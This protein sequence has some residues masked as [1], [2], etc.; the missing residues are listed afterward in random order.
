M[1]AH[2][3]FDDLPGFRPGIIFGAIVPQAKEGSSGFRVGG[4]PDASES[5]AQG[6]DSGP[7]VLPLPF[8]AQTLPDF[9]GFS[10]EPSP[11]GTVG[12]VAGAS[13]EG[14][15]DVEAERGALVLAGERCIPVK[16]E[17]ASVAEVH[18]AVAVDAHGEGVPPEVE[19]AFVVGMQLRGR[20]VGDVA[21]SVGGGVQVVLKPGLGGLVSAAAFARFGGDGRIRAENV[22]GGH[23]SRAE[24][25]QRPA[26]RR[27]TWCGCGVQRS[28]AGAGGDCGVCGRGL[29]GRD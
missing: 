19:T 12:V 3:G 4:L 14:I 29:C 1:F 9:F 26:G 27:T 17:V 5:A 13:L 10:E 16:A 22:A 25:W 20:P 28:D 15:G 18:G 6:G 2:E 24:V 11:L 23:G 21:A 8:A 7:G